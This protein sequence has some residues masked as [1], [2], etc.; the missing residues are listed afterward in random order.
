MKVNKTICIILIWSLTLPLLAFEVKIIN[1]TGVEVGYDLSASPTCCFNYVAEVGPYSEYDYNYISWSATPPNTTEMTLTADGSTNV[2]YRYWIR[3]PSN[4]GAVL[5]FD[6]GANSPAND[7]NDTNSE[8]RESC[9][10]MPV[11]GVSEPYI[12]LW[13]HDEPLGYQP[14]VGPRLSLKLDYKQREV[15]AGYNT[16][17]FG[18]GKKWNCSWLSY[19]TQSG[20]TSYAINFPDGGQRTYLTNVI[21]LL[22]ESELSGNTTTGFTLSYPDGSQKIYGFVVTNSSGVFQEAF[23]SQSLNPQGQGITFNYTSLTSSGIPTVRLQSVVDGDGRTTHLYYNS[24]N[25]YS[26]NLISAVADP[27]G[28]TNYLAYN[29][30]GNLTNL[31]DAAGNSTGVNYD[32]N[33][34]VT[35]MT[36]PYGT[37]CFALTDTVGTNQAPSGRSVLV[38]R[39]DTSQELYLYQD[40]APGVASSYT[41]TLVP[42][43]PFTNIFDNADLNVRNT[44]YW[45]PRQF[46]N[47]S[48]NIVSLFTANDFA[49]ARRKHWLIENSTNVVSGTLSLEQ[50]PS[51]D[52]GGNTSG[53]LTWYDYPGKPYAE[54]QGMSFLPSTVAK[55]LPDGTTSYVYKVRNAYGL[56]VTNI[57]SYSVNGD[58]QQRTTLYTYAPNNIDLI[59]QTNA[60]GIQVVSNSYNAFHEITNSYDALN[61]QTVSLYNNNRQPVSTIQPNGLTVTNIYG[62]NNL[63]MS[64]IVAGYTTNSFTY[65]NDLVAS[66]VDSRGLS[67]TY[68]WDNLNRLTGMTYPDGSTVSNIY[69]IL[70]RTATKDRMGNWTHFAYDALERLT[71]EIN[72]LNNVTRYN[73]CTCGSLE[74]IVDAETNSTQYFYDNQGNRTEVIYA[75]GYTVSSTFNLLRQVGNISDS[76]GNSVTN[77]YDNQGLLV[78][79]ANS[80]GLLITNSYDVLDRITNSVDANNVSILITFDNLNRVLTRKYPDNGVESFGYTPNY[81]TATS[82]TNQ[83]T[84]VVFYAYDLLNRKTN[85]VYFGVSTNGYVFDGPGDLLKLSDGNQNTTT[86]VYDQYGRVTN[87]LDAAG[88]LIFKYQYDSDDRL[89]NRWTPAKGATSYA[90]DGVGNLT[91]V[92]YPVSPAIHLNYDALN[93]LT[94]M[95]DG[96][97]TTAYGYDQVGQ[98]LSEGGLWPNDTVSYNYTNRLRTGMSIQA[99]NSS[100]WT[101]AYG[102]DDARRLKT[103]T[104]PAGSFGYVYDPVRLKCVDQ[105]NLPNGA[106]ITNAF[107]SVARLLSTKLVNS[108]SA[109]LDSYTYFYNPAAQRT[110]VTR[111][112]GDAVSYTYDTDGELKTAIGKETSGTTNRWQEQFGY[113]YDGAGNLYQRT[114]NTLL[115]TFSVNNLNELATL[116]NA[117]QLT[118][119]G[120]TT[121]PATNVTVNSLASIL[122]ADTTFASTNQSLV[123]GNNTYTAIAK[124]VYGRSSTNSVTVTLQTTNDFN[125]DLN[126]NLLSDGTRNFVY[127]DENELISVWVANTWSNNFVYDGVMRR[128][129][130]RDFSWNGSSW[131]Q[132]NEVYFIYD[133]NVVVQERNANYLPTVTYTRGIDLS[134]N[135]QGAGGIGGLLARSDNTQM[136]I[137]NS[138][139]H[140]YYHA[141]GNGNVTMLINNLQGV[142]AKYLYDP[143]G[144]TLSM[145]GPLASANTYRFSSKEWNANSCL[146]YYLYRFYDANLQR[147]PNRDPIQERQQMNLYEFVNNNCANA[148][149]LLGLLSKCDCDR[150]RRQILDK[151]EGLWDDLAKYNPLL[152]GA[153]GPNWT[154]GGHFKEILNWQRGIGNDLVKYWRECNDDDDPPIPEWVIEIDSLRVPPPI[155]PKPNAIIYIP[156]SDN[157]W[158]GVATASGAASA[159]AATVATGGVLGGAVGAVARGG[160]GA[161]VAAF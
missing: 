88:N 122:Y 46:S 80:A 25:S 75:D 60:L 116:T 11:W 38:T 1:T 158:Y 104:S 51:P 87:K 16:N 68:S 26:T 140:V 127:D 84:N 77:V 144:N 95:V 159:V 160:A 74:S 8:C 7:N 148:I 123:S 142:A 56:V 65:V 118:V 143:Y 61:E 99:P 59:T 70:D 132:T 137:G 6:I 3:D 98:L 124:D 91:N 89:T 107:D 42:T 76:S 149:D 72:S 79:S 102:Y 121:S 27:F 44:F 147:W 153:G 145:S 115:Q 92:N 10:G 125:Y 133:G 103:V 119:A 111:T 35:N 58:V 54:A 96:V 48:T 90:Y 106:D 146:Y 57:S 32:T 37:T 156:G 85:E 30:V 138:A 108:S 83:I 151:A 69:S 40:Y 150:L 36:T 113:A 110:S 43:T 157:F 31:T 4:D 105:L 78:S 22:T 130:E 55:V 128:R 71:N 12:S 114:N 17:W 152:D 52:N 120:S 34:W 20:P 134:G 14:A 112:A 129:I 39:P 41:N 45:G 13:L 101:Q 50:D 136:I 63:L 141:D 81:S 131:N 49:K 62:A 154:P 64:T 53:Q 23:L 97:G 9:C 94:G 155:Y 126:G 82:F 139:A 5:T 109:V 24:T 33:D 2:Q 135:L 19:L 161:A 93:R 21:D 66:S 18:L 67:I 28:R 86:W 29:M 100:P 73:Y 117:G 47:L 15:N